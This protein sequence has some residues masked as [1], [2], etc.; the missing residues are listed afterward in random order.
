MCLYRLT[1]SI[2][3]FDD[4]PEACIA[5]KI[6]RKM[7]DEKGV[8]YLPLY[9]SG[10]LFRHGAPYSDYRQLQWPRIGGGWGMRDPVHSWDNSV[11]RSDCGAYYAAGVHAYASVLGAKQTLRAM[12]DTMDKVI[13]RVL[14]RGPICEGTEL[15][16]SHGPT[17]SVNVVVY[18]EMTILEEV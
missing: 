1:K 17:D 7:K 9:N 13:V 16:D 4:M 2:A 3:R 10:Q 12:H 14:L 18:K 5:A 15:I 8:H 11:E 6:V